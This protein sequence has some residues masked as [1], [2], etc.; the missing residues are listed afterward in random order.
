MGD[1]KYYEYQRNGSGKALLSKPARLKKHFSVTQCRNFLKSKLSCKNQKKSL[2][3]RLKNLTSRFLKSRVSCGKQKKI[4]QDKLDEIKR[5]KLKNKVRNSRAVAKRAENKKFMEDFKL[6]HQLKETGK[7]P[8][9]L[10]FH[11]YKDYYEKRSSKLM[12]KEKKK[13]KENKRS[14]SKSKKITPFNIQHL[15][16][17]R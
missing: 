3:N 16:K 17:R 4:L 10:P 2:Q 6:F 13:E 8:K 15:V 14:S 11:Q 12:E 1:L 5:K 9:Q 7:I